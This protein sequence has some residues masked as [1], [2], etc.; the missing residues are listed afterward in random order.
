LP[1]APFLVA[2]LLTAAP[3]LLT[4]QQ[5]AR[6]CA[7]PVWNVDS[8][9]SAADSTRPNLGSTGWTEPK[10]ALTGGVVGVLAGLAVGLWR[11]RYVEWSTSRSCGREVPRSVALFGGLGFLIGM[12]VSGDAGRHGE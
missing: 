7:S 6:P 10:G 11:C 8:I 2:V 9:A 3:G 1:T 5:I 4:A 12:V